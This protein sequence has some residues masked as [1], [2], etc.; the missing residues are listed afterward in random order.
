M[1]KLVAVPLTSFAQL[2]T[3]SNVAITTTAG[4]QITVK[5]DI[6]NMPGT[7]IDNSGTIDLSGDWINNSGNNCFGISTGT[8][9]FN[10]ANQTIGGTSP[11]VFNNLMLQGSGIKSLLINTTSGGGNATPAGVLTLTA[12]LL[13]LNSKT[14]FISN[15]NTNAISSAAG[16]LISEKV[17]N[18]SKVDWNTGN[19]FGNHTIPFINAAGVSIPFTYSLVS[20]NPQHVIVATYPTSAANTPYP[21]IPNLVNTIA[22]L[23][24]G[25]AANIVDRYWQ[26]D[27]Q[28]S[29]TTADLTFSFDPSTEAPTSGTGLIYAQCWNN[30]NTWMSP[31]PSQ[32]NPSLGKVVL[33]TNRTY[34]T[35][36]LAKGSSPLPLELI[37]FSATLNKNKTVDVAWETAAEINNDY[38]TVERSKDAIEFEKVGIVDG[39]GNST[40][41]LNYGIVDEQ[42][43]N[44]ISYYRLKQTDY[45]GNFSYSDIVA[46]NNQGDG[47]AKA[48]IFPNP[49]T[50]RAYVAVNLSI[51]NAGD[52]SFELYNV[53][54]ENVLSTR[55]SQLNSFGENVFGFDKNNL[56]PGTYF[57][58]LN[59]RSENL[60]QGKLTVQ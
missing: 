3:N 43:Y 55:L 54:G 21:T 47:S 30:I 20:G 48:N 4:T 9:I 16:F 56:E 60:T 45:N 42:P 10:G 13:D 14:L 46:V 39:A 18:S 19:T 5:G 49:M 7:T 57:F 40:I 36:G 31:L 59:D 2:L 8:V 29:A 27:V 38:F 33:F 51:K 53:L 1:M 41:L 15:P 24:N 25:S 11:T 6:A 23:G 32:T 50:E 34:G 52:L 26:V 58:R 44:G 28:D 37:N 12:T 35:Y 22:S 17:D